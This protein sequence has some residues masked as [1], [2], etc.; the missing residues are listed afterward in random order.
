M[1]KLRAKNVYNLVKSSFLVQGISV[2]ILCD[3]SMHLL[4][5]DYF[6]SLYRGE[7][8]FSL[9]PLEFKLTV[10][11]EPPSLPAGSI[12]VV[13]SPYITSYSYG[14]DLYFASEGGSIVCFNP[15]TKDAYGFLTRGVLKD[16]LVL[17]SLIGMALAEA[18]KYYG[19]Y[20]L[21]SAGLYGN[22]MG[23]LITGDGG[24][25]K[26]TA[27]LS[28]VREGF[29]YVSDDSLFFEELDGEIFVHPLYTDFHVD[30]DLIKRFP[31]IARVTNLPIAWGAKISANISEVFQDSFIPQV[32]PNIIIFPRIV[33]EQKSRLYPLNKLEMFGRLLK[34]IM[35]AADKEISKN[36]LKVLEKLVKQAAGFELLGGRDIYEDPRMIIRLIS[37]VTV[38]DGNNTENKDEF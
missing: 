9:E 24:C 5:S 2:H 37:R 8:R 18:F 25:G 34:Q 17:H 10:V 33:P 26:T 14:K 36:Q 12:S 31:E 6:N 1:L 35:I 11:E 7:K 30:Q 16:P 29:K 3:N 4:I 13:E 19:I 22:G 28:L 32:K 23:C 27:S 15:I 38:Y 21:H 20:F